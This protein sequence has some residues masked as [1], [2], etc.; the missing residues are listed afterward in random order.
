MPDRYR[1][2]SSKCER[3]LP[4]PH[5]LTGNTP[6]VS[7]GS[8]V[9]SNVETNH[10]SVYGSTVNR[11][12]SLITGNGSVV[13][14]AQTESYLNGYLSST[15]H[16]P[17]KRYVPTTNMTTDIYS[18]STIVLP[19]HQQVTMVGTQIIH[20]CNKFIKQFLN[21]SQNTRNLSQSNSNTLTSSYRYRM[22]CCSNMDALGESNSNNNIYTVHDAH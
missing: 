14:N 22:K 17:V 16:T 1:E 18:D 6:L 3:F 2:V 19:H 4:P 5:Y 7:S 15:V 12:G 20:N 9:I 21:F 13:T 11:H 8:S 10:L